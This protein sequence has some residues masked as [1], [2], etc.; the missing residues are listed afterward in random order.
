MDERLRALNRFGLGARPEDLA[1]LTDPRRWLRTQLDAAPPVLTPPAEASPQ[2]IAKAIRSLRMLAGEDRDA[3]QQAR[4]S[5]IAI[6]A[7]ES[8]AA[9][10]ARIN[11]QRPF[12]ERLVA[13]WSNHLCVSNRAKI[14]VAPLSGSYE[15]EAIRPH[16]LGRFED[17]VL[18][19]ARHP[20]MLA[21][22]DNF[23]SIGPASIAARAARRGGRSRGLNE[24]YARELLELHTLGVDG[25]YAQ[26]DVQ[27]LAR[28]LTGW[29]IGGLLSRAAGAQAVRRPHG[30]PSSRAGTFDGNAPAGEGDIRFQ[31][32]EFM[33]EP[34]TRTVLG[35]KYPEGGAAQAERIIRD[36][37]R[38][39]S[40][41][42][43]VASK[44]VRH[45]IADQP[46]QGAV[47]RIARVF[48]ETDGDLRATSAALIDLPDAWQADHRK[49]RTPQDWLVASLRAL[50]VTDVPEL[51]L[52]A[53][54]QL[55]QPLWG[56]PSPKGFGDTLGEWADP[57]ALL[58]RGEMARTLAR[59]ATR[60]RREPQALASVADIG[61]SDPLR[62]VLAD[63]EVPVTDRVAL[64][65]ASPALQWR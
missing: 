65:L 25:G 60:G 27:E 21:Y 5:L 3:R 11:T 29:T 53:L 37:C 31:Y 57:D 42:R 44:L 12:V 50:G 41:S 45:F 7:A 62:A 22:L 14:L 36:L 56:P 51:A 33:H 64:A 28:A 30:R 43:F 35:T 18:A 26:A 9:L 1:T 17:L 24:N 13:F 19:S 58:N 20:A 48:Q 32:V 34:G 49:F 52:V 4:R 55:R 38:H 6:A 46:P 63:A 15:R 39:R 54:Q 59:R 23:Q 8:R 61:A 16:V 40:T 47:D 10:S 2:A